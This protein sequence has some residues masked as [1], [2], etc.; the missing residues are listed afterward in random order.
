MTLPRFERVTRYSLNLVRLAR[1]VLIFLKCVVKFFD[2]N[3][4]GTIR[5]SDPQLRRLLLYPP[6]LPGR[7]LF[8]QSKV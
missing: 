1:F 2:D 4:P 7:D 6:E 8:L 3:D 5:T